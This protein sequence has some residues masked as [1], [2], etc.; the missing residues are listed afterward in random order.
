MAAQS[1]IASGGVHAY[2]NKLLWEILELGLPEWYVHPIYKVVYPT[3]CAFQEACTS[4]PITFADGLL[5]MLTAP[6]PPSIDDFKKLAPAPHSSKLSKKWVVYL[7][8]YE[9]EGRVFRIY[10][11]TG[12][13]ADDGARSRMIIYEKNNRTGIPRL[14]KHAISQGF[15]KT[16]TTLLCWSDMPPLGFTTRTRQRFLSLE[17]LFQMIFF[18]ATAYHLDSVWLPLMPWSRDKVSWRPLNGQVALREHCRGDLETAPEALAIIAQNRAARKR[19]RHNERGRARSRANRHMWHIWSKKY[20]QA[21]RKSGRIACAVCKVVF[22]QQYFKDVH[23]QTEKHKKNAATIATGGIVTPT[24][25]AL[26]TRRLR[27]QNKASGRYPCHTC[28]LYCS[29]AHHLKTHLASARHIAAAAAADE[30]MED[31]DSE[32][33]EDDIDSECGSDCCADDLP[34]MDSA[35]LSEPGSEI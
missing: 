32:Y 10:I 20:F 29:E 28:L 26:K 31:V 35:T 19:E 4:I 2:V 5:D 13:D 21:V 18:S 23:M 27:A 12:T 1:K 7:H 30:A 16:H 6:T 15:V 33:D 14:V 22:N 8:I 17:G 11:G 34:D 9:L 3:E 24:A 25:A